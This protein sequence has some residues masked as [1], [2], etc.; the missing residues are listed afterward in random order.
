[1]RREVQAREEVQDRLQA[2]LAAREAALAAREAGLA[3]QEPELESRAGALSTQEAELAA[4]EAALAAREAALSLRE[5]EIGSRAQA[6]PSEVGCASPAQQALA[7][8]AAAVQA[9]NIRPA[10]VNTTPRSRQP[11]G[12]AASPGAAGNSVGKPKGRGRI[13]RIT[14]VQ[15]R[16]DRGVHSVSARGTDGGGHSSS[17]DREAAYPA[18]REHDPQDGRNSEAR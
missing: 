5:A 10:V 11:G 16:R 18:C 12:A 17:T 13:L 15:V 3:A 2:D 8:A 4:R 1:M 9:E 7:E 14:D 6:A